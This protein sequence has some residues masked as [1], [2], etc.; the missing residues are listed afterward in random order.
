MSHEFTISYYSLLQNCVAN[1]INQLYILMLFLFIKIC[2]FR[3]RF[4]RRNSSKNKFK[5]KICISLFANL[6][7]CILVQC[8]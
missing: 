6:V 8:R 2:Y 4:A 5:L 1:F 3:V 7:R